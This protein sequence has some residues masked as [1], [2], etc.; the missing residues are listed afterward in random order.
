M[1][2]NKANCELIAVCAF[3]AATKQ[4]T[5]VNYEKYYKYKYSKPNINS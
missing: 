3:N 2:V 4:V 5:L 1:I